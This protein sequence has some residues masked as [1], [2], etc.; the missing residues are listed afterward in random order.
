[1]KLKN[2]NDFL[3]AEV[4]RL[5]KDNEDFHNLLWNDEFDKKPKNF[6][7]S[8]PIKNLNFISYKALNLP[9]H[10]YSIDE[11]YE[12]ENIMFDEQIQQSFQCCVHK[13]DNV[14]SVNQGVANTFDLPPL[15]D[16]SCIENEE[17]PSCIVNDDSTYY[18]SIHFTD[19]L[20]TENENTLCKI[21]SI[22][23][24][25]FLQI[26]MSDSTIV[27][28]SSKSKTNINLSDLSF[29]ANEN[30][31]RYLSR[32]KASID[33]F[34]PVQVKLFFCQFLSMLLALNLFKPTSVKMLV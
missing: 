7:N 32:I 20:K 23:D 4:H 21:S 5:K 2:Q 14:I 9:N 11:D 15:T 28:N 30:P 22:E 26:E 13:N 31:I 18:K 25:K 10:S 19:Y 33:T 3:S 27:T 8:T 16:F 24:E 1:M 17:L 29:F 34:K 6:S 12:A